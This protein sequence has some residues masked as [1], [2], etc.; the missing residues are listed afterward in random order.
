MRKKCRLDHV[1]KAPLAQSVGRRFASARLRV[2]EIACNGFAERPENE[3]A[4]LRPG[5]SLTRPLSFC[6]VAFHSLCPK[7]RQ[8]Y[9]WRRSRNITNSRSRPRHALKNY[10][11]YVVGH[12]QLYED[13]R[14]C[15]LIS[16]NDEKKNAE[17]LAPVTTADSSIKS[18]SAFRKMACFYAM[19]SRCAD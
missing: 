18:S 4:G 7:A 17:F 1:V 9:R 12:V 2:V 15:H 13:I 6:T 8:L 10:S 11:N 14:G 19:L 5:A 3:G 16:S